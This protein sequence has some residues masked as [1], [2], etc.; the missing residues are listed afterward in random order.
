[1]AFHWAVATRNADWKETGQTRNLQTL[2]AKTPFLHICVEDCR[3]F[4]ENPEKKHH[5]TPIPKRQL[6]NKPKNKSQKTRRP[7]E[8]RTE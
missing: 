3:E 1:M 2:D 7:K 8:A 6:S 4:L 5:N